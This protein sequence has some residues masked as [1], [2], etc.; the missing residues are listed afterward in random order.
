MMT[1]ASILMGSKTTITLERYFLQLQER[2]KSTFGL[3]H[4]KQGP[5]MIVFHYLFLLNLHLEKL[6]FCTYHASALHCLIL[7]SLG[8]SN[9]QKII[10]KLA[11]GSVW[12][13][14]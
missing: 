13:V 4:S 8:I 3:E 6:V 9:T 2:G 10:E 12:V 1:N 5:C 7:K 11:D 14:C